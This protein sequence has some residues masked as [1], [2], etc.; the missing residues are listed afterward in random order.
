M[1]YRLFTGDSGQ[2]LSE[3][4]FYAELPVPGVDFGVIAGN[5]GQKISF[6]EPNDGL[7][8]VEETKLEGMKD[9]LVLDHAHTFIMN[10]R[11]TFEQSKR[12]LETGSFDH[13]EGNP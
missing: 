1:I 8:A 10:S 9:F 3:E 12:F 5:K 6:S 13:P 11:D 7:V 2:K 4:A